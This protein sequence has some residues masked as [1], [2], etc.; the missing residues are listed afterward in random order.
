[1]RRTDLSRRLGKVVTIIEAGIAEGRDIE[2][3]IAKLHDELGLKASKP[4][5][6]TT[7]VLVSYKDKDFEGT[8]KKNDILS[9]DDN[10][11]EGGIKD[12]KTL[13]ATARIEYINNSAEDDNRIDVSLIAEVEYKDNKGKKHLAYPVLKQWNIDIE[14]SN[15]EDDTKDDEVV[16]PTHEEVVEEVVEIDNNTNDNIDTEDE[17]KEDNEIVN[18]EDD[19]MEDYKKNIRALLTILFMDRFFGSVPSEELCK[20]VLDKIHSIYLVT[21]LKGLYSNIEDIKDDMDE[22][23]M[24]VKRILDTL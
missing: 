1:M 18:T 9:Y 21:Y 19:G 16:E 23:R 3:M 20:L 10:A 24:I 2:K 8:L 17:I 13:S 11:G 6:T 14:D 15:I 7:G 5:K 22:R 12:I 4:V